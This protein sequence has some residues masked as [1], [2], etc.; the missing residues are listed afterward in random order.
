MSGSVIRMWLR[1]LDVEEYTDSFI[2]NGYDDLETI[3]L[4]ERE[5]LEAIGVIKQDHQDYL[6]AS[7]KVL[8]ERGGAWV[9]LLY[10]ETT[11]VGHEKF[12]S[13]NE[14]G[15]NDK[16]IYGSS[17]P[18]SYN[19]SIFPQSDETDSEESSREERKFRG[20]SMQRNYGCDFSEGDHNFQL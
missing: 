18:E 19:S 9:Y 3:K 17:G 2:D 10:C 15:P 6:L 11:D 12:E 5:D 4:I 8:K 14:Y 13:D 7:V 1:F 16:I 20:S